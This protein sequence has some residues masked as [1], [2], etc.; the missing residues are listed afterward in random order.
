MSNKYNN[1]EQS[2]LQ[3][4]QNQTGC[5]LLVI[6]VAMLAFVLTDLVSTGSSI[7][8]SNDNSIG[9]IAEQPNF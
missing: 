4:I 9:K 2:V 7:F 8:G 6:G 5:L 3:K 1:E